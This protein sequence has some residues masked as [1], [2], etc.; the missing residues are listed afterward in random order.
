MPKYNP[1]YNDTYCYI[2]RCKDINIIDCYIGMTTNFKNRK[3]IHKH[4]CN[5]VKKNH[6][7]LYTFI[8][9]N[10]GWD[11]W[12]MEVIDRFSC[13]DKVEAN[14]KE[15]EWIHK[16]NPS[17]NKN[18]P[19]M[20]SDGKSSED[21]TKQGKQKYRQACLSVAYNELPKFKNEIELLH[22]ELTNKNDI[23]S[24][25]ENENK[26]LKEEIIKLNEAKTRIKTLLSVIIEDF[27]WKLSIYTINI[28][29]KLN[30]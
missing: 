7:K 25:L 12:E 23:I 14:K 19:I 16:I 20:L 13:N 18:T 26:L 28:A 5:D 30:I 27:K 2:I 22:N 21:T 9:N 11:N 10:G 3:H 17:L 15:V 4:D 6:I 8:N 1:N 29:I 24:S